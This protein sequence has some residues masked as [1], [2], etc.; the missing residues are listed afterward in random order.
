MQVTLFSG[1]KGK[2]LPPLPPVTLQKSLAAQDL[3][4]GQGSLNSDAFSPRYGPFTYHQL[5]QMSGC[6]PHE[7]DAV[8]RKV[9]LFEWISF[10]E[11]ENE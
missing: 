10:A 6:G 7:G 5:Q 2:V 3:A 11:M 1:A 8:F 9:A 4:S